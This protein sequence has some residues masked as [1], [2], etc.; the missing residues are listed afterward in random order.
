L[1]SSLNFKITTGSSS[2]NKIRIKELFISI[3]S[4]TSKNQQCSRKNWQRTIN[5]LAGF[6]LS[7]FENCNYIPKLVL[8]IFE[9]WCANG[10]IPGLITDGYQFLVL[11]TTWCWIMTQHPPNVVLG[12]F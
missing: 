5:F 7:F 4:N 2:L 3:M 8:W 11:R 6:L 9:N 10:H 1:G 12:F